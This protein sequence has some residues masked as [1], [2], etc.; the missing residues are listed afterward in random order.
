MSLSSPLYCQ[1]VKWYEEEGGTDLA[2][3]Q[4]GRNVPVLLALF[5]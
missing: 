4:R 5:G 3:G 1:L 2:F